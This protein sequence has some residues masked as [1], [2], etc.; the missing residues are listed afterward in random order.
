MIVAASVTNGAH[1]AA[2]F[3]PVLDD[4]KSNLRRA[5]SRRRVRT[6]VADAGYWDDANVTGLAARGID[7]FIATG[8]QRRGEPELLT[9]RGLIPAGATP[10]QR[11]AR[12]LRTKSGRAVYA[13]RKAIVE[14]VFGQLTVRQDAKRL[15]LRGLPGATG[16]WFLHLFCHNAHK[17]HTAGGLTLL[18]P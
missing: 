6:V 5:G 15:R 10:K 8:R 3:K 12:K 11:M 17:L 14:P 13:R 18:A 9:P 7:P 4:T 2:A 16:E 1:D